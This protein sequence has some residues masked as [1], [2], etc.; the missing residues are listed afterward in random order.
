MQTSK[1][2]VDLALYIRVNYVVIRNCR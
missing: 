1:L 2:R